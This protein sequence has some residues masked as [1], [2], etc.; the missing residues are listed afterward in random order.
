M[1]KKS[2]IVAL[3][4][5]VALALTG[6][7]PNTSSTPEA[8]T[9]APSASTTPSTSTPKA[10]SSPSKSAEATKNTDKAA[11]N[12]KPVSESSDASE[13]LNKLTV[14][15]ESGSDT[16]ERDYFNHW[17]SN[18][19]TGCDTRF[20]VLVEESV[21][22]AVTSG[23]SVVSG[24]W[25]SVYDGKTVTDPK[26]LDIDHMIPLKEA[27]ESGASKWDASKRE[28][29]ANDLDFADALVAVTAASNRSKSDRDPAS[30]LPSDVSNRCSYVS[31]WIAVKTHWNLTIDAKEKSAISNQLSSCGSGTQVT[32]APKAET[33]AP[34]AVQS[35]PVEAVAPATPAAGG[36]DPQFPSCK[37]AL[38]AGYG[39]YTK[40]DSEYAWYRDG[41]GD[42]TV[43]EK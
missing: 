9:S 21:S 22:K 42:G 5:L 17:V 25:K 6:C 1:N 12:Q 2:L 32:S 37:A 4:M 33:P 11:E 8:A 10:E 24:E 39:P 41:D 29:Y 16:Y 18:N 40:A 19:K 3:P 38:S 14:V 43:C 13:A 35:K 36:A 7:T 30:Y 27:W 31:K 20:A 28:A 34:A 15:E 23:C 26:K